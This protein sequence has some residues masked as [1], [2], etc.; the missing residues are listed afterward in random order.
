MKNKSNSR[1]KNNIGFIYSINSTN[2]LS[3][4]KET[5][6]RHYMNSVSFSKSNWISLISTKNNSRSKWLTFRSDILL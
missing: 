2:L 4:I 6:Y 5:V 1:V 3:H